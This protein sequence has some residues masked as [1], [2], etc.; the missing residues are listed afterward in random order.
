MFTRKGQFDF[1]A[2]RDD[3]KSTANH[4]PEVNI[5]AAEGELIADMLAER[6]F[7]NDPKEGSFS[8]SNRST[9]HKSPRDSN[10]Q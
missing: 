2:E 7:E 3:R 4:A 8:F 1:K 5:R 10:R 9:M 6:N